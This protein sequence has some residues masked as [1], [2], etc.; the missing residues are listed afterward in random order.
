M[1][2]KISN[3]RMALVG[4]VLLALGHYAFGEW[5]FHPGLA[6]WWEG[7]FWADMPWAAAVPA[8]IWLGWLGIT[9]GSKDVARAE[10]LMFATLLVGD[11]V[12]FLVWRHGPVFGVRLS[13]DYW[14]WWTYWLPVVVVIGNGVVAREWW[15]EVRRP[16]LTRD[17]RELTW[18]QAGL[19]AAA[20]AVGAGAVLLVLVRLVLP[21]MPMN[22]FTLD[23]ASDLLVREEWR[24][25]FEFVV[26]SGPWR[27]RRVGALLDHVEL[28]NRQ[29]SRFY[30][31]LDATAFQQWILSP[32]VDT[33]P[34]AELDWRR[35]LWETFSTEVRQEHEP[36]KGARVVVRRLRERVGI[37]AAYPY[38]VGVETIWTQGMTDE[39]GFE[40]IY[41]AA[42]RSVGIAAR[43]GERRQ[44]ELLADGKWRLAP[45]PLLLTN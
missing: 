28:A 29:R 16:G 3:T 23:A 43:L 14:Y 5:V 38:R 36:G 42:L 15:L 20:L 18:T 13:R 45:R 2:D 40:R 6:V 10:F 37:S 21:Q 30:Q 39:A 19:R 26:Q 1:E 27:G 17:K 12:C 44:A 33:T 11:W 31:G 24:S 4:A 8:L 25:D 7:L 34:V 35:T 41:V 22:D 9:L 32:V